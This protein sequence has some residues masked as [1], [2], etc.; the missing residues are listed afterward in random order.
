MFEDVAVQLLPEGE[1]RR[2]VQVPL[3]PKHLDSVQWFTMSFTF[4][5]SAKCG[6]PKL[7]E[8]FFK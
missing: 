1:Q 7:I 3:V 2:P 4:D 6:N 5:I 8:H